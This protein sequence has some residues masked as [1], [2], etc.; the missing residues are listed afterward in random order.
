[1]ATEFHEVRYNNTQDIIS[2]TPE[3]GWCP[4]SEIM[5]S[6]FLINT[7]PPHSH[8]T[9]AEYG[10]F[11]MKWFIVNYYRKGATEIHL[12]FDNPGQQQTPKKFERA[13]RNNMS[14]LSSEHMCISVSVDEGIPF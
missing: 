5:E 2:S 7:T 9:M 1:M 6:M 10:K 13:R 3:D 4:D 11:L 8:K 12:I 14:N